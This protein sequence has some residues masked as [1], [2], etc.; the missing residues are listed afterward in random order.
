MLGMSRVG[1]W[2][3]WG[4]LVGNSA[5]AKAAIDATPSANEHAQMFSD[6]W[7]WMRVLC[8]WLLDLLQ[9]LAGLTG[10]WGAA[11]IL[12]AVLVRLVTYP[13]ARRALVEQKRFNETQERLKPTLAHIKQNYKGGE[14]AER[15][16]ELY[17]EN[18][19]NPAA[20]MKPLLIVLLQLPIFIALFQILRQAPELRNV[21]FLWLADLSQPDH[22]F[23]LGIPLPWFGGYFNVMPLIMVATIMLA[24][25]TAPGEAQG[26]SARKRHW[27]TGL[28]ALVFFIAFYSFPAGL[29]L[30]WITTNLLHVAQQLL[31]SA[32]SSSAPVAVTR[33]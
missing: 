12:V 8:F 28:M 26:S 29:V 19:V 6:L 20:G 30:Y 11:I 7:G 23:A 3:A 4:V 18:K 25:M 9:W 32:P 27:I 2:A 10:S 33:E 14:Q 13:L 24:A 16:I 1:I 31:V 15:I 5:A 17:K 22:A 21:S